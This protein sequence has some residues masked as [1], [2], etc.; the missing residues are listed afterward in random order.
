MSANCRIVLLCS[1]NP[2]ANVTYHYLRDRFEMAGVVM[3]DPVPRSQFLRRRVKKLG[4][5]KVADQLVFQALIVPILRRSTA[6]RAAEIIRTSGLSED[7]IDAAVITHVTSA[8]SEDCTSALNRLAPAVVVICG[9]RILSKTLLESIPATFIN[10]H[11]GITPLYRGVHG[12]YWALAQGD[13]EHCGVTVHL[14]DSGIDTGGILYQTKIIPTAADN[15]AT[16]PL[17][18]LAAG[19]PLLERAV[20]DA[21]EGRVTRVP[22]PAGQSRLWTHPGVTDYLRIRSAKRVR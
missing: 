22:A 14:V 8:N 9:T 20:S 13:A 19:L 4:L 7:P 2:A 18:Q 5:F 11:A 1:D 16:Y 3:E 6:A 12:G 10:M 17:L 21:L 15:F